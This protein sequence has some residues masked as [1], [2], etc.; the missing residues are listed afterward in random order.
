[1]KHKR[2]EIIA[3][4]N[5]KGGVGKTTTAVNLG[6]ALAFKGKKILVIDLDPQ[7][8]TTTAFGV[9]KKEV[10]KTIYDVLSE[11]EKVKDVSRE[12]EVKKM[13]FVP[14]SRA[15]AKFELE[16]SENEKNIFILRNALEE[17]KEDYDYVLID[18]PPSLGVLTIS[19]LTAS[20]NVLIPV[21]TE[22]F[23]LEGLSDLIGTINRVKENFN[24]D[25]FIKGILLTMSDERT[26]LSKQV[27]K[28]V[29]EFFKN[30]V[31]KV[32]IPRNIRLSEAPSYGLP[33]Q[34]YDNKSS[35]ASA[36]KKLAKEI[37]L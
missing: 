26:N 29:R 13:F 30:K 11:K 16:T 22:Y 32:V 23:A 15:L 35:G 5:Q 7:S 9:S 33:I 14:A 3:V 2:A 21:Q 18:S 20:N 27:E 4:A 37:L 19:S 24:K 12:T 28:E 31:Y 25:L 8:N 36:Y 6:A 34:L 1:M 10:T 17:I